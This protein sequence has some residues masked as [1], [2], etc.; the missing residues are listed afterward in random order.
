M[1]AHKIGRLTRQMSGTYSPKI[2]QA[3]TTT[4]KLMSNHANQAGKPCLL[5]KLS[6]A[7]IPSKPTLYHQCTIQYP[8]KIN[9]SSVAPAAAEGKRLADELSFGRWSFVVMAFTV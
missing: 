3:A 5:K 9:R 7:T 4:S 6:V 1:E 8:A 2:R